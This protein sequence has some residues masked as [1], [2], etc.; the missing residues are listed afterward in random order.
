VHLFARH[1]STYVTSVAFAIAF[2]ALCFLPNWSL[3]RR[4]IFLKI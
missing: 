4:K 2:T 3:W 1:G